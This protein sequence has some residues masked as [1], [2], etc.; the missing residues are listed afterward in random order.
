MLRITP[1][2]GVI[3]GATQQV[4]YTAPDSA[5]NNR[6]V[7]TKLVVTNRGDKL[8]ATSDSG[9]ETNI[10]GTVMEYL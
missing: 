2:E 4:I 3:I 8:E 5:A 1:I 10:K 6:A 9:A 7:I